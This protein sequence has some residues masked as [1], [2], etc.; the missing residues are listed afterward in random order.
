MQIRQELK[1]LIT[2]EVLASK[3]LNEIDEARQT[4]KIEQKKR[5]DKLEFSIEM[6][7]LMADF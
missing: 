2:K 6:N 1:K 5:K 7:R 3:Q 4:N